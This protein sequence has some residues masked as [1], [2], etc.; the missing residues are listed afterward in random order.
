MNGITGDPAPR[1][2]HLADYGGVYSGSFIPMLAAVART[3]LDRGWSAELIFSEASKDRMWLAEL[4]EAGIP[5]RF[6]DIGSRA[7]P[8]RWASW[9]A[10]E[11]SAGRWMTR[12]TRAIL[13]VLDE[14]RAPTILHTHFSSFDVPSAHAARRALHSAV[15]W[16][17]HGMRRPGVAP[18]LSGFI[19]YRVFARNVTDV[20]CV[21][22]HLA[23]DIQRFGGASRVTFVPNGIDVRRFAPASPAERERARTNLGIPPR[24]TLLL[25]FG[26]YW[27]LKG[28]DLYLAAIES[29]LR[30]RASS[31][32]RAITIGREEARAAVAAAGLQSQVTVLEPTQEVRDLYS[33]ADL[34]VS[35]SR[36]EGVPLAVFEA[37]AMGLPVVASDIPGHAFVGEAVR[38]CRLAALDP[39]A[40]ATSIAEVLDL[41]TEARMREESWARDW[42]RDHLDIRLW[43]PALMQ[44][45]ERLLSTMPEVEGAQASATA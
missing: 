42:V 5:Y 34:F 44:T 37:L 28:G 35:P 24:T 15:I 23:S 11:A 17:R 26:W 30:N 2:I 19:N 18:L 20:L 6:V 10:E 31:T 13:G 22:P 36:R 32:L 38:A 25:H 4:D 40:L 7:G 1:L 3:A 43:P 41:D 45:Y 12:L 39:L 8:G 27:E 29:L 33:A 21:G 9:L 14:S 16:H